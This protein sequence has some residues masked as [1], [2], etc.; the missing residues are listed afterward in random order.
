MATVAMADMVV[1]AATAATGTNQ[2]GLRDQALISE[3]R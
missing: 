1:T 3:R 2:P